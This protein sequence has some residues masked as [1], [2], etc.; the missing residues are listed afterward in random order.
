MTNIQQS[1]HQPHILFLKEKTIHDQYEKEFKNDYHISFLSPIK[2]EYKP[3]NELVNTLM[4]DSFTSKYEGII[5]TSKNAFISINHTLKNDPLTNQLNLPIYLNTTLFVVGHESLSYSPFTYDKIFIA[6]GYASDLC[7]KI[8][9]YWNKYEKTMKPLLFLCG[10]IHLPTIPSFLSLY[11]IQYEKIILYNTN[12]FDNPDFVLN[13][14]KVLHTNFFHVPLFIVFF[15]PSGVV[16]FF[17]HSDESIIQKIKNETNI[18]LCAIGKTTE[19]KLKSVINKYEISN[20]KP[21]IVPL[22]PSSI[23]L[24]QSIKMIHCEK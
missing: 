8:R 1:N 17:S 14:Y 13:L 15:S 12:I 11:D 24:F 3:C 21:I 18:Y 6:N 19:K 23:H 16:S 5:I 9:L 4:D 20:H 2:I 7:E 10:K 22:Y